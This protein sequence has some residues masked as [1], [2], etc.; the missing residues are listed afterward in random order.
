MHGRYTKASTLALHVRHHTHTCTLD[1]YRCILSLGHTVASR[2]IHTHQGSHIRVPHAT[3]YTC[4][5][6]VGHWQ[7]TCLVCTANDL[8]DA[9]SLNNI[10]ITSTMIDSQLGVGDCLHYRMKEQHMLCQHAAW[11]FRSAQFLSAVVLY[12]NGPSA[13]QVISSTLN[14]TL[15]VRDIISKQRTHCQMSNL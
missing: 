3:S 5:S 14:D 15:T 8:V 4:T 7:Q 10:H 6:L 2:C 12:I 11:T 13:S 9:C 1:T